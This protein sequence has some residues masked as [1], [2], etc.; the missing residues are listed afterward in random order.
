M[1][2]QYLFNI[3]NKHYSYS[4]RIRQKSSC[5]YSLFGQ[6]FQNLFGENGMHIIYRSILSLHNH[7]S[8]ITGESIS[9]SKQQRTTNMLQFNIKQVSKKSWA[10]QMLCYMSLKLGV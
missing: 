6:Y 10:K 5:N 4:T 8:F 7:A 1:P 9:E 2:N 3:P